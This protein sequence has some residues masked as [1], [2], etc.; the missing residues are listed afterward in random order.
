MSN[1]ASVISGRAVGGP[2]K[3]AVVAS[4]LMGTISGSGT[5]N[6]ATTGIVTI[7]MMKKA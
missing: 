1:I 7:P 6:V 2:A 4:S 5:A 3:V